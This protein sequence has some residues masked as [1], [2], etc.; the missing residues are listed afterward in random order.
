MAT[1]KL[2]Q[3]PAFDNTR[4]SQALAVLA[5]RFCIDVTFHHP[6]A[7]KFLDKA[8]ASHMRFCISI[9][10][11][12]QW[13]FTAYPSEPILSHCAAEVMWTSPS[14]MEKIFVRLD[15]KLRSGMIDKGKQGELITRILTSFAKD[16]CIMDLPVPPPPS[17]HFKHCQ[18][19][20]VVDW[21]EK[22]FGPK[23]W[24]A[25]ESQCTLAKT[26]FEGAKINFT[27][28]IGM[29]GHIAGGKN[30]PKNTFKYVLVF[31]IARPHHSLEFSVLKTG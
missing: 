25:D 30:V 29:T 15:E 11:D 14:V 2:L 5:Q 10:E 12:R 21:L 31:I 27:H 20:R 17:D 24:P 23:F 28:W 13:K 9:S 26:A 8:V 18:S 4:S 3:A 19:V 7:A 16:L 22:L 1:M 6:K